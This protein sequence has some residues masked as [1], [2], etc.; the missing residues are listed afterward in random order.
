M[1]SEGQIIH[2]IQCELADG[3]KPDKD[4]YY[5]FSRKELAEGAKI[6]LS[7]F[8]SHKDEVV[9]YFSSWCNLKSWAHYDEYAGEILYVDVSY[10]RGK[11]KFRQNPITI[12]SK[13]SYLWA[14]RPLDSYFAYDC[15]D[16][17]HRRRTNGRMRY[18]AI[19]WTWDADL[20][21][22]VIADGQ[23]DRLNAIIDNPPMDSIIMQQAAKT[24]SL[25]TVVLL[26]AGYHPNNLAPSLYRAVGAMFP[27]LC[28]YLIQHGANPNEIVQQGYS[29]MHPVEGMDR[30]GEDWEKVVHIL[31]DAGGDLTSGN[32]N[33]ASFAGAVFSKGSDDL[34][35]YYID[36]LFAKGLIKEMSVTGQTPLSIAR[37]YNESAAKYIETLIGT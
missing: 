15:F 30:H 32:F 3:R 7:T 4:G 36:A 17:K 9:R 26:D 2:Y 23:A 24:Y 12:N 27:E 11:L 31:I 29:S 16:E 22:Q 37:I 1:S 19:P 18:G 8:D 13:L 20:W 34:C 21:E 14:L 25:P 33:V 5:A 35:K 28:A 10:E 6:S